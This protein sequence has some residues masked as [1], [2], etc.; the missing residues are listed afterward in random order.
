MGQLGTE[1]L[2]VL[3]LGAGDLAGAGVLGP[4]GVPW[5]G[6]ARPTMTVR[7]AGAGLPRPHPRRL[8]LPS[9]SVGRHRTAAP[10][11]PTG[12]PAASVLSHRRWGERGAWRFG[13]G[14]RL[15]EDRAGSPKTAA[16]RGLFWLWGVPAERMGFF[17]GP[18]WTD[19]LWGAGC[20]MP[21]PMP[22]PMPVPVLVPGCLPR[23]SA[24]CSKLPV[25]YRMRRRRGRGWWTAGL[26]SPGAPS[27]WASRGGGR[28]LRL[29]RR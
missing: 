18:C 11:P 29:W 1:M 4:P 20:G 22:M 13:Q 24:P 9:D 12:H 19:G 2:G 15:R 6:R 23:F 7:P 17:R 27:G 5:A 16:L 10:A 8:R 3:F 21:M 26:G 25:S 28:V 14:R